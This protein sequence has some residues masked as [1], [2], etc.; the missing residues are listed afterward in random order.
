VGENEAFRGT[1]ERVAAAGEAGA[2]C[3]GR[4]GFVAA[5]VRFARRSSRRVLGVDRVNDLVGI[6][7]PPRRPAGWRAPGPRPAGRADVAPRAGEDL[8]HLCGDWR[9]FQRLDGH[10]WSLDDLVTA[11]FAAAHAPATPARILDLGCGIGSVLLMLTWRFPDAD[12]TGVEAQTVS[13]DLARRSIAW[14]GVEKR[15]RLHH[16]DFRDTATLDRLGRFDLVT[17]TPPYLVPGTARESTRPQ[18]GPCS[19]QHRGGVDAYC[20]AA[21]RVLAPGGTFVVCDQA[22][23]APRVHGAA[24]AAGLVVTHEI[25]VVPRAGKAPLLAVFALRHTGDVTETPPPL[26]VR[27]ERGVRTAACRAMRAAMGLP[28]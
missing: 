28:P 27:D 17:G 16:G 26:V 19:F 12:A 6:V 20:T 18:K 5:R 14:N 8:C 11:W 23:G 21:A 3:S 9:I 7:R 13:V 4:T 22:T 10:R 2:A 24:R 1:R 15:V 25:T